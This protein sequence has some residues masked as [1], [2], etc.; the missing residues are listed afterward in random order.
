MTAD[1]NLEKYN[2]PEVVDY[3]KKAEGLQPSEAYLFKRYL[4]PGMSILDI[5]V[6]GGRTTPYL[7][8]IAARYVGA[9]Y[10]NA[11]VEVCKKRFPAL[12][13]CHADATDMRVFQDNEFDAVVFSFNG[14]DA[15]RSH[16][17]RAKCLKEIARILKSGGIFI[18]SSHN[19]R[20][21]GVWPQYRG[22]RGYQ[23]AWR[24]IRAF[25]KS[26]SLFWRQVR[27]ATYAPGQGFVKDPVHGGMDHYVSIPET[28]TPQL[29][30]VALNVL[31]IVA[32]PSRKI[33]I[34]A[35]VPWY[36]YAC[37]KRS[38]NE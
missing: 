5:G 12:E 20:V 19:A 23:M 14:I 31:E 8:K 28:M 35:I 1:P 32:G 21:L 15:I 13:F 30:A 26:L 9:D 6:G 24:T 36:Y 3:Y 17:E 27:R 18:F 33:R 25:G 34:R 2:E 11:M 29:Q 4:K 7:S 10:S 37:T 22:A 16:E 38:D